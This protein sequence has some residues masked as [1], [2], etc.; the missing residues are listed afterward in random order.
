MEYSEHKKQFEELYNEQF[1]DCDLALLEKKHPKSRV[2]ARRNRIKDLAF[3]VLWELLKVVSV[4]EIESN[5][6]YDQVPE[7]NPEL[8]VLK[9]KRNATSLHLKQNTPK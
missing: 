5:R 1:L 3:E 9:K 7:V 2:L 4:F 6:G 8:S